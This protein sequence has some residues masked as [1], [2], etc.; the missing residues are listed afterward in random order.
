MASVYRKRGWQTWHLRI[1]QAH[2]VDARELV[3]DLLRALD[4]AQPDDSVVD[5]EVLDPA[6]VELARQPLV[7]VEVDLHLER[8]PGLQ[9]DVDESQLAVHEV[10]VERQALPSGRLDE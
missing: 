9:L 5:L 8:E 2:P 4:V 7:T 3:G 6:P 1:R 10:V